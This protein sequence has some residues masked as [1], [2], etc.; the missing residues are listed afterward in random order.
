M[1]FDVL[2]CGPILTNAYLLSEPAL[3]KAILIDAPGDSWALVKPR[4]AQT[5]C[6]LTEVWL[7]HGH[8][9]HI[10]GA[11]ELVRETGAL[12]RAHPADR[13]LLE[14]PGS[15]LAFALPGLQLEPV[16]AAQD[17]GHGL[18]LTA[19]GHEVEVRHVPGHCPGSVLFYFRAEGI[20]FVG[21]T[22]FAQT[23]ARTDL[24]FADHHQLLRSIREQI[25]TLPARTALLPGHGMPTTVA[26]AQETL[27]EFFSPV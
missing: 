4:L 11:P 19:F 15:Q 5:G 3:G 7:T 26:L 13:R 9:D 25:F 22:V 12:V 24:P 17:F 10:M 2:T 16:V 6:Q 14:S 23:I 20:A 21:D 1:K 8:W 18:L 27:A